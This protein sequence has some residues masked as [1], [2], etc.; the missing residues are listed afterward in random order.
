MNKNNNKEKEM[1]DWNLY[2]ISADKQEDNSNKS[3]T[4]SQIINNLNY[5][6]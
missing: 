6:I 1:S 2:S 5:S 4:E 3:T